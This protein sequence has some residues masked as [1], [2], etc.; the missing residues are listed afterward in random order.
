[1]PRRWWE[2][3]RMDGT[4]MRSA[5]IAEMAWQ[6]RL[7][8]RPQMRRWLVIDACDQR[9][10][11]PNN[12]SRW[13]CFFF[14]SKLIA[15]LFQGIRIWFLLKINYFSRTQWGDSFLLLAVYMYCL[16][17]QICCSAWRVNYENLFR[18]A[19]PLRQSCCYW[20]KEKAV[21]LIS[22][23]D[24]ILYLGLLLNQCKSSC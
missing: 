4:D 9:W 15:S 17:L 13:S 22:K 3:K 16:S 10:G 5:R 24:K 23:Y 8:P 6:T 12:S 7:V 18:H 11:I 21:T 2:R 1:M 14:P 19:I 20:D